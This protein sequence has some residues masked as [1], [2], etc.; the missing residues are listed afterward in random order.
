VEKHF[1]HIFIFDVLAEGVDDFIEY[2]PDDML[3]VKFLHDLID[4]IK[5]L[6]KID[7]VLRLTPLLVL[8]PLPLITF[9]M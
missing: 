2:L 4:P 8:T 1:S 5:H 6:I 3:V 7:D 9:I